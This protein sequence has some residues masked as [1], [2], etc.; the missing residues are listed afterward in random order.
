MARQNLYKGYSSFEF[1][2]NKTF[3][4]R[5]IELVKLDLLNHIFTPKGSRVMMPTFGTLIPEIVFEPMD[6]DTLD[7]LH[8]EIKGVLDYDPRVEI[9]KL[10]VVP[11]YDTNTVIVECSLLYVELDTVDDFDLNIQFED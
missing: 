2:K 8:S 4:L 10:V 7:E 9:L 5:D 1:E 3:T 11:D 6:T